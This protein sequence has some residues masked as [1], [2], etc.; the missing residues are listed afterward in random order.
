LP[1]ETECQAA[2]QEADG[3]PITGFVPEDVAALVTLAQKCATAIGWH[4]NSP[5][6]QHVS[7][8]EVI[9]M[10]D[11]VTAA[12]KD[13]TAFANLGYE[14][15]AQG[16]HGPLA[17]LR[18]E[19]ENARIRLLFHPQRSTLPFRVAFPIFVANLVEHARKAAGLSES[20]AVATGVLPVQSFG[21]GSSVTVRGPG[22]FGR[23]ERTDDR[24]MVSGIP[25]PRAGEYRLAAGSITQ[26]ICTSLLST[27]ETSLAAVSEMEFA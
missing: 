21:A 9:F 20:S 23:T 10:E 11:P 8:D 1:E 7:F 18:S 5:L 25:A 26:T 4:R 12:G 19:G 15:L 27:S 24:G 17:L 3:A 13:E 16:P 6:L 14:I 2:S 22:K